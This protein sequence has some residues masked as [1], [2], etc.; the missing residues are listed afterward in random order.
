MNDTVHANVCTNILIFLSFHQ[1]VRT[2][3]SAKTMCKFTKGT[4]V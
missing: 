4:E 2:Y 3:E 1:T